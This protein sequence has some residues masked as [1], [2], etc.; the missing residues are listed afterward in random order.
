MKMVHDLNHAFKTKDS[1]EFDVTIK[2]GDSL[3][4]SNKFML[5]SSSSVFKVMFESNMIESQTNEVKI[6]DFQPEVVEA[7]LEYIHT[8]CS[9]NL[10]TSPQEMFAAAD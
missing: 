4:K 7:M 10:F 6:M 2:C 1:M 5:T 3:F 9:N 8:G